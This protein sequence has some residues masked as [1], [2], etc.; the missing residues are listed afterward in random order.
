MKLMAL[1]NALKIN[2]FLFQMFC[3][4]YVNYIEP[5]L[6]VARIFDWVGVGLGGKPKLQ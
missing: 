1:I 5:L 4:V 6:G 3:I 2:H